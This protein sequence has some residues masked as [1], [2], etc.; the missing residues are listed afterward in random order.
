MPHVPLPESNALVSYLSWYHPAVSFVTLGYSSA[1][2]RQSLL[3][4]PT[5]PRHGT[6]L[7]ERAAL[8]NR[9]LNNMLDLTRGNVFP[10]P[11]QYFLLVHF[12]NDHSVAPTG[13]Y[14]PL[15]VKSFQKF[16]TEPSFAAL[17]AELNEQEGQERN[18]ADERY[19]KTIRGPL[20]YLLAIPGKDI[21][22]KP[23]SVFN[24]WLHLPDEK[25]AV[26]KDVIDLLHAASPCESPHL[27]PLILRE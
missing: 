16:N 18:A 19:E 25:Q 8:Y 6:S 26:V 3:T 9:I 1:S 12:L 23:S 14:R 21:R 5:G 7:D 17:A 22:G 15:D 4:P 24:E 10:F 27:R 20:D 11:F 2:I 13:H